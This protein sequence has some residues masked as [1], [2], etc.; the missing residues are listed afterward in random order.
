MPNEKNTLKFIIFA[1]NLALSAQHSFD[2]E[3]VTY[4]LIF[5]LSLI[6]YYFVFQLSLVYFHYVGAR[7]DP[8][9]YLKIHKD[10]PL[11]SYASIISIPFRSM[12]DYYVLI[13][14]LT[15]RLSKI[16]FSYREF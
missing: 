13:M 2:Y 1:F 11:F 6:I 14:D 8:R 16:L 15:I 3:N 12:Q 4:L 7:Y 5:L 10:C 9:I